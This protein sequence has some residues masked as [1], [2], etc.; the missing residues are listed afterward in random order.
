MNSHADTC[1]VPRSVPI[2]TRPARTDVMS[3]GGAPAQSGFFASPG[4]RLMPTKTSASEIPPYEARITEGQDAVTVR[5]ATADKR[6]PFARAW[7]FQSAAILL[8]PAT[9]A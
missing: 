9:Q 5:G 7:L 1:A 8:S 3:N 4:S 6:S 2:P